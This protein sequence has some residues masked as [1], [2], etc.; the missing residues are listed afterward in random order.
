MH[1]RESDPSGLAVGTCSHLDRARHDLTLSPGQ[2]GNLQSET[3][4]ARRQSAKSICPKTFV[5][6]SRCAHCFCSLEF[7]AWICFFMFF[8]Q[9]LQ[10]HKIGNGNPKANV[11]VFMT[12]KMHFINQVWIVFRLTSNS[13]D[14]D[15]FCF[16]LFKDL[17]AQALEM[18][19]EIDRRLRLPRDGTRQLEVTH[20]VF[21]WSS[22]RI[23]LVDALN[24][25]WSQSAELFK[26]TLE[27]L[28][29]RR[30]LCKLMV[31]KCHEMP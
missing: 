18:E 15:G 12:D 13:D 16:T 7:D 28:R 11:R 30:N 9:R 19:L 14:S 29:G 22:T 25:E 2:V 3:I 24:E 20:G 26:P 21:T 8:P 4:G 10:I 17:L 5:Q 27:Q 1:E 23:F 6:I 31:P